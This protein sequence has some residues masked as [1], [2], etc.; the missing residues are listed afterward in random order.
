MV[1]QIQGNM[2]LQVIFSKALYKMDQ[3]LLIIQIKHL[4]KMEKEVKIQQF[5]DQ[6]LLVQV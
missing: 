4:I 1:M 6:D 5:K 3:D 2:R